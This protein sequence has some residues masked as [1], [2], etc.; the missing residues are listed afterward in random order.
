M[1]GL[2]GTLD[3]IV[4]AR[5][6]QHYLREEFVQSLSHDGL[7]ALMRCLTRARNRDRRDDVTLD[8]LAREIARRQSPL[9]AVCAVGAVGVC[10]ERCDFVPGA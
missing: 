8:Y 10:D 1:T 7:M 2:A 9:C 3:A 5:D 6:E 4:A